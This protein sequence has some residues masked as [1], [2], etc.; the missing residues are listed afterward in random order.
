[1]TPR[2]CSNFNS[3]TITTETDKQKSNL[4][5]EMVCDHPVCLHVSPST[6]TWRW[7]SSDFLCHDVD[8]TQ[9]DWM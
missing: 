4:S 8:Q 5:Q 3:D 7:K 9:A 2:A 6:D 1:M